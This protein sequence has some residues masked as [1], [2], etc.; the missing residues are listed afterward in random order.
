MDAPGT[1]VVEKTRHRPG[2]SP[3]Q[4]FYACGPQRATLAE[5][6]RDA[7]GLVAQLDLAGFVR[8]QVRALAEIRDTLTDQ[9]KE[10]SRMSTALDDL[11]A[12]VAKFGADAAQAVAALKAESEQV[13][14]LAKQLAATT[15]GGADAVSAAD[16][17]AI[18]DQLKA[19]SDRLEQALA[20]LPAPPAV[21]A[22]APAAAPPPPAPT[23]PPTNP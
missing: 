18:T 17:A 15:A 20:A 4:V 14:S 6:Q 22:A 21:P 19:S 13:A 11:R 5:A 16:V 3:E 7:A 1:L 2:H 12:E 8:V 23:P 9:T 10:I